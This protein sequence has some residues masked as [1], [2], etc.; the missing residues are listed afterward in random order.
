MASKKTKKNLLFI[1]PWFVLLLFMCFFQFDAPQEKE[2]KALTWKDGEC[3]T[4]NP[5][6]V[7]EISRNPEKQWFADARLGAQYDGIIRNK[8]NMPVFDWRLYIEL[9][10]NQKKYTIDSSW[11]GQYSIEDGIMTILPPSDYNKEIQADSQ[12]TFGMILY[13]PAS[14]NPDS[15][16]LEYSQEI[17]ATIT[18]FYWAG[19]FVLF[20]SFVA[21][22]TTGLLNIRISNMRRKREQDRHIIEKTMELFANTIEAKDSYTRGHSMRVAYYARNIARLMGLPEEDQQNVYF[23]AILHDVGKIG[24][25][26]TILNKPGRLTTDEMEVMRTHAE[27]SAEILKGFDSVPFI[28]ETLRHHHEW[29]NG[30]GYPDH[31]KGREIPLFSRIICVADC[32][33]AMTSDRCYRSKLPIGQAVEKLKAGAGTQFDPDIIPFM[34][35]LIENREAPIQIQTQVLL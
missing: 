5:D 29:F 23:S 33:D 17:K 11:N 34:L 10:G 20:G 19:W 14:F 13:S 26:D 21:Y 4:E 16:T 1:I 9:P 31:L 24:I 3:T 28:C 8:S 35:E 32:F 27:K 22:V 25:S 15:V 18:P 6:I 12:I 2:W 30:E 7:V